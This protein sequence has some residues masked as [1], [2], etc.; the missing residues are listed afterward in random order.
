MAK[1]F[2]EG[3]ITMNT[4]WGGTDN[5]APLSGRQVQD[6]IKD[7]FN[8]KVGWVGLNETSGKYVLTKDEATFNEYIKTV[9]NENKDGD[10]SKIIGSFKAPFEYSAEIKLTNPPTGYM[11]VLKG[12]TGVKLSFYV[13]TKDAQGALFKEAYSYRITN[14]QNDG[15]QKS[16]PGHIDFPAPGTTINEVEVNIDSLLSVGT[17]N[18]TIT[19]TGRDSD[20]TTFKTAT[21]KVVNLAIEDKFDISTVYSFNGTNIEI[22]S[23]N[24]DVTTNTSATVMWYL[25]NKLID[26]TRVTSSGNNTLLYNLDK[27]VISN[28]VHTLMFY[29]ESQEG[30]VATPFRTPI[31]YRNFFVASSYNGPKPL[32]SMSFELPFDE[33]YLKGTLMPSIFNAQEYADVILPFAIYTTNS[34]EPITIMVA[35]GGETKYEEYTTILAETGKVINQKITLTKEGEAKIKLTSGEQETFE[36]GPFEVANN[37]LIKEPELNNVILSLDAKGRNN[38]QDGFDVWTSSFPKHEYSA[39]FNNFRW[40]TNNGWNNDML[41]ISNG[42]SVEIPFAPF[43]S[44][45]LFNNGY[46]FE[47]E[48]STKNVYNE[49]GVVCEIMN[50][51]KTS[52]IKITASEAIFQIDSKRKVSSK[53][54]SGETYRIAFAKTP[55]GTKADDYKNQRFVKLYVNGVLCG[56][57]EFDFTTDFINDSTIKLQG[58]KDVEVE[59]RSIMVAQRELTYDDILS[60]YLFNHLNTN[61]K[62]EK[63][64]INNIYNDNAQISPD[65]LKEQIPVMIFYQIRD[66]RGEAEEPIE[67]LELEFSDKGYEIWMD[68]D[69]TDPMDETRNFYWAN[70]CIRPQGTSSMKYPKKNYRIYTQRDSE[71]GYLDRTMIYEGAEKDKYLKAKSKG[72][73]YPDKYEPTEAEKNDSNAIKKKLKKRKYSFRGNAAKVKCWCLKADFAES[74]GTHNTGVARLWNDVMRNGKFLTEAQRT[75]D[76]NKGIY[77]YDV[78]TTVDGFPI[79]LFYKS[80]DDD[81]IKF[82]GKYNFNNDKSTEDVFGFTG[83]EELETKTYEYIP[84]GYTKPIIQTET[85]TDEN[86]KEVKVP[87]ATIAYYPVDFENPNEDSDTY[88][89][90]R[91]E[92]GNDL[93]YM[94]RTPEMFSNPRMECWEILSSGSKLALFQQTEWTMNEDNEKIGYYDETGAFQESFESRFPDCGEFYHTYNLDRLIKWLTSCQYLK[95][96]NNNGEGKLVTMTEDELKEL[97]NYTGSLTIHL[98]EINKPSSDTFKF[99]FDGNASYSKTEWS[100]I[101][102]DVTKEEQDAEGNEIPVYAYRP[103]IGLTDSD[104]VDKNVVVI[105]GELPTDTVEGADLIKI[106]EYYYYWGYEKVY[107]TTTLPSSELMGYKYICLYPSIEYY[108]W[109]DFLYFE[110]FL[111]PKTY[112]DTSYYRA[113][114]FAVEKYEHFQLDMT[115]AYYV[116][117]MRFGGVDQTVKNAMLT[118]EGSANNN[119]ITLPSKWYFI[120]YDNDTILGVKNDGTLVFDPY[121]TRNTIEES[122]KNGDFYCYAGRNSTLWNNFEGDFDFMSLVPSVDTRLNTDGGLTY[123]N[124]IDMFN[125]KQSG[126]WCETVYNWDA[127]VKYIETFTNRNKDMENA[128]QG[129]DAKATFKYLLNV[130]GPRSA[131][132]EWWLAKRFNIFDSYYT[133]GSFKSDVVTFKCNGPSKQDDKAI[134]TSGED[135]FY[136]YYKNNPDSAYKTPTTI[137]PGYTWELTVTADATIGDPH[138]IFG[139]PNIEKID[140]RPIAYRLTEMQMGN[141]KNASVGT[142]LKEL[143]I[144]D[145]ENPQIISS[146]K[147]FGGTDMMEK[148]ETIDLTGCENITSFGA[149]PNLKEYYAAGSSISSFSFNNGGN[150]ETIEL[151]V[152]L[153]DLTLVETDNLSWDGI[154]FFDIEEVSEGIYKK[155][156]ITDFS[157]QDSF[158]YLKIESVSSLLQNHNF[159]LNWLNSRKERNLSL[160]SCRVYLNPIEW[161][162]TGDEVSKLFVLKNINERDIAGKIHIDKKLTLDE[163]T[164][165]TSI[166]GTNCFDKGARLEII[167]ERGIYIASESGD[168][169]TITEGNGANVYKLIL[170]GGDGTIKP[171][172]WVVNITEIVNGTVSG[173]KSGIKTTKT[174]DKS[175]LYSIEVDELKRNVSGI[176]IILTYNITTDAGPSSIGM[177]DAYI[178]T[179]LKRTYPSGEFSEISGPMSIATTDLKTYEFIVK[180]ENGEDFKGNGIYY[181]K[182]SLTGEACENTTE[183]GKTWVE[184]SETSPLTCK[185]KPNYLMSSKFNVILDVYKKLEGVE[186]HIFRLTKPVNLSNPDILLVRDENPALFQRLWEFGFTTDDNILLKSDARFIEAN[187]VGKG[188]TVPFKDIFSGYTGYKTD[189]ELSSEDVKFEDFSQLEGF[190]YLSTIPNNMFKGC[191]NLKRVSLYQHLY[192]IGDSAFNGCALQSIEIPNGLDSIGAYAFDGCNNLRNINI[193]DSVTKIGENVLCNCSN[194][195]T[196]SLGNGITTIPYRAFYDSKKISTLEIGNG[197]TIIDKEAFN[198]CE[199]LQK[200]VLPETISEIVFNEETNPFMRCN[201]LSFE[202]G[203]ETYEVIEGTLYFNGTDRKWLLKQN[204]NAVVN[205][206]DTLYVASYGLCGMKLSDLVITENLIFA[207]TNV[208]NA[209]A[210][211]TITLKSLSSFHENCEAMLSETK[212]NAYNFAPSET[213]IPK[214]CFSSSKAS[215]IVLPDSIN[216]IEDEA[217]I[218]CT[219]IKTLT[220]PSKVNYIGNKAFSRNGKLEAIYFEPLSVPERGNLNG[221]IDIINEVWAVFKGMYV[222]GDVLSDYRNAWGDYVEYIQLRTLPTTGYFRI[223]ENGAIHFSGTFDTPVSD[224][225]VGGVKPVQSPNGYYKFTVQEG[226]ENFNINYK[227]TIYKFTENYCTI[228]IGEN[229][230]L[231]SGNGVDFTRG[232]TKKFGTLISGETWGYDAQ[233]KG[234]RPASGL[235]HNTSS[236]IMLDLKQYAD[237]NGFVTIKLGQRS[238]SRYDYLAITENDGETPI[239][240]EIV[241]EPIKLTSLQDINDNDIEIKLPAKDSC[242]FTYKKDGSNSYYFDCVWIKSIGTPIFNEPVLGDEYV[243]E[244][245]ITVGTE[246]NQYEIPTDITFNITNGTFYNVDVLASQGTITLKLPKNE[247]YTISG[248]D[249]MIGKKHIVAFNDYVFNTNG[250]VEPID[251]RYTYYIGEYYLENDGTVS[252]WESGMPSKIVYLYATYDADYY[253]Y[254]VFYR[255]KWSNGSANGEDAY[256]VANSDLNSLHTD[257]YENTH[258]MNALLGDNAIATKALS[259]SHFKE[260]IDWY[261][262]SFYELDDIYNSEL[263]YLFNGKSLWTSNIKNEK[264]AWYFKDG[265]AIMDLRSK[266]YDIINIGKRKV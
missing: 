153:V 138:A 160:A 227:G 51:N 220:I 49:D 43:S 164:M 79:A 194:L 16:V 259:I 168:G 213:T 68:I 159:V 17:N 263:R 46:T 77:K 158:T 130:Q 251:L 234:F 233:L 231:Y 92:N 190:E 118:T 149:L 96:V 176:R 205:T 191:S 258:L 55:T 45:T 120:N 44:S 184:L 200:L 81:E 239:E 31:Y 18:I 111:E 179:V 114:K 70:A 56:L 22:L 185:V 247:T 66:N 97:P 187:S 174:I 169:D 34:N 90:M 133:T 80:L 183:D 23:V 28:G 104:V 4:D 175:L 222:Y 47:I 113:L 84:I 243:E 151:P 201:S 211:E 14:T 62:N 127:R 141:I 264:N 103:V 33:R 20:A 5:Q 50:A 155:T 256:Y 197:V 21:I 217:F 181:T 242:Y 106:G 37:P 244:V 193:P 42:T 35:E 253:I 215:S 10:V 82:L 261:L 135:V 58:S 38:K 195:T 203:N 152:G 154:K 139:S 87:K 212:Y 170:V 98:H 237:E 102:E 73:P 250:S 91:D 65:K 182:W 248:K 32:F 257:G 262:P 105:E 236:T 224:V 57:E 254:P 108:V 94:L 230:S 78:R 30:D 27:S 202:G 245:V 128:A 24:Y 147:I 122:D 3:E 76:K 162:L 119:D 219:D 167:A 137:K 48:F 189:S 178:I 1:N 15:T 69:Y 165:L 223:I 107:Y 115:A 157:K 196:V 173:I 25:D 177:D 260:M 100:K 39:K 252:K 63:Y 172:N 126:Q 53:F 198:G 86:G 145:H 61:V 229:T 64:R 11:S 6:F 40:S 140:F 216:R 8:T 143:L 7:T 188:N 221:N 265:N 110:D 75:A 29:V 123:Q 85:E 134:I 60:N 206:E 121:M 166:F 210:G 204:P 148:L 41:I 129:D 150:I 54:K 19:V 109:K 238:E 218:G 52:G 136:G 9:S 88:A 131:H 192:A 207:G 171:E 132:R 99:K 74:S 83:G 146:F 225:T 226:V 144:G 26:K 71:S 125:N 13:Q 72:E 12:E 241:G 266:E 246:A 2:Y 214:R 255:N 116:Y 89:C 124:T 142:K 199:A 209:S 186:T 180:D 101:S 117:L 232:I 208:L 228:F 235:K 67:R 156:E 163:V 95:I 59:L 93:Y 161:H 112:P 240:F 36:I 249:F